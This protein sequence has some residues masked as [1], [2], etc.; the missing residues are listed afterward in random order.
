[1]VNDILIRLNIIDLVMAVIIGRVIFIGYTEGFIIE[2]FKLVAMFLATFVVLHYF[3][4]LAALAQG[5]MPLPLPVL[6]FL[7]YVFLWLVVIS[8]FAIVRSGWML[9]FKIDKK[10]I[11]SS[12]VGGCLAVPRAVLVIGMTFILIFISGNKALDDSARKSLTAFYIM[13][14]STDIYNY[15]YDNWILKFFPAEK[16]A[17]R[18]F[19]IL[20]QAKKENAKAAAQRRQ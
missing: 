4:S 7:S 6:E 14:I 11:L 10:T 20:E 1:M 16:K 3:C 12:I 5:S 18:L 9:G 15:T 17:D 2:S 13:N 19:A 8:L